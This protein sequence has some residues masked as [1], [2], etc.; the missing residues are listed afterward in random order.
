MLSAVVFPQTPNGVAAGFREVVI[1]LALVGWC[2]IGLPGQ[3]P[4]GHNIKGQRFQIRSFQA[5]TLYS[6][7]RFAPLFS[8]FGRS[9]LGFLIQL[10]LLSSRCIGFAR[11]CCLS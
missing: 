10:G 9:R 5:G 3:A 2:A 11:G 6:L 8:G 4:P 1:P 7:S